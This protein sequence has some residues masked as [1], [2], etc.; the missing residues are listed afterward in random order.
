MTFKAR[1]MMVL[2]AR[3]TAVCEICGDM[4]R[5]NIMLKY[6]EKNH[7][8]CTTFSQN[9]GLKAIVLLYISWWYKSI[10]CK[11]RIMAFYVRFHLASAR[12]KRSFLT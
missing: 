2:R 1:L 8:S 6:L 10:H 4:N 5:F 12:N 7:C 3:D 11:L 9:I